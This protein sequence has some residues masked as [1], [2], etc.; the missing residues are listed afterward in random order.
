MSDDY[1]LRIEGFKELKMGKKQGT[2]SFLI[3]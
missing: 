2:Q 3:K 1:V